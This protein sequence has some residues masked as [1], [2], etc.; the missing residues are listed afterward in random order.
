L[1]TF[2]FYHSLSDLPAA[3]DIV[4]GLKP[5]RSPVQR[6]LRRLKEIGA[7]VAT[8]QA[9]TSRYRQLAALARATEK[10]NDL[11]EYVAANVTRQERTILEGII[12]RWRR[13]V[14]E[15][16]GEVGASEE[17]GPVANPYVAGNPVMGDL[18]VGREDILR[19]LV[20]LWNKEGQCPSVVI[21][22]HR[23]MGKTSILHNLGGRIG[24]RTIMVDFNMQRVGMITNTGEM[25]YNLALAMYDALSTDQREKLGEP[26]EDAFIHH[27]PY[28]SF[29]RFLKQFERIRARRRFII[30]V[31]EFELIEHMIVE[32]HL[33]ARLL[34]FWRGLIQTYPWYIM[35]FAGLHTLQEMTQDYWNPL[36]GSVKAIPVS[37]LNH[38]AAWR[39][40]TQPTPDFTLDYDPEAVERII[41]LTNGQPY[42]I[43]LIGHG[44]VTRFNRQTF[45]EG[46]E[47]PWRF[48][49]AD[50][51]TII[52]SPELY[53]DG[54]A[55]FSGVWRLAEQGAPGQQAILTRLTLDPA[56]T[57]ELAHLTGMSL[58]QTEAA[59]RTLKR[60]DVLHR[61][62]EL[63]ISYSDHPD[64]ILT[65]DMWD[66]TVELM[67]RWVARRDEN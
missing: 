8:Y 58:E 17:T 37:F 59:L 67:R 3:V 24:P 34:A 35:A 62:D 11:S 45:E 12:Y 33:E 14:S 51:E 61:I 48:T 26:D 10:L 57:A 16:S 18:F 6:A 38:E 63:Y 25:L 23:R 65:G 4:S 42:L 21:Y 36:F 56:T 53:R 66:F 5:Y 49:V 27:N 39:L 22:G 55:Y 30:T 40:I 20:E 13:L 60:H 28:I 46:V 54:D 64:D 29:D 43:Q 41:S 50:V 47:R 19:R 7:E 31:D 15:A 1:T 32:G 52:N 9:A 44:L 2:L